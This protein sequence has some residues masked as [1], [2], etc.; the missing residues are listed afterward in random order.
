MKNET[1]WIIV[2]DNEEIL[3]SE[4]LAIDQESIQNS[5]PVQSSFFVPYKTKA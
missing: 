4:S 3:H 1:F 2:D 5:Y